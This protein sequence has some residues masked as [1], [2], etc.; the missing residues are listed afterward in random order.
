[1]PELLCVPASPLGSF[2]RLL[3]AGVGVGIFGMLGLRMLP[4]LG[5]GMFAMPGVVILP[6][7][8]PLPPWN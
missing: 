4:V 2:D 8:P 5:E 3:I 7:P 6:I 1:M